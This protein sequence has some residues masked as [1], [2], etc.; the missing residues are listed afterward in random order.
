MTLQRGLFVSFEGI[1]GSGKTTQ[2]NLLAERLRGLGYPVEVTCEPGGTA[3]GAAI[4]ELLLFKATESIA[5]ETE[6][7][8]YL[9]SRAQNVREKIFPSLKENKIVLADRF[10]DSTVA[11]QGYGS[12]LGEGIIWTLDRFATAGLQPDLTI[13]L[14]VPVEVAL[15]RLS[16]DQLAETGAEKPI[17]RMHARKQE[18]FERTR[19]GYLQLAY[20]FPG[21][22]RIIDSTQP[23]EAVAAAIWQLVLPIVQAC[24]QKPS[25]A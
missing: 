5:P 13:L 11:Y 3:V 21:R 20:K 2:L 17:E 1:D 19:L 23:I 15:S 16:R 9:A 24:L 18:F 4:R 14:D 12:R 6:T 22:I 7:L 25:K 8:L 10:S